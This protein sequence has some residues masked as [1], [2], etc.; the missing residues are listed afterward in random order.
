MPKNEEQPRSKKPIIIAALL[1]G[2]VLAG[3]GY[4]FWQK[5]INDAAREAALQ[6]LV[7]T[8]QPYTE[9]V[10]PPEPEPPPTPMPEPLA[11]PIPPAPKPA[12]HA[13]KTPPAP[14]PVAAVSPCEQ[15]RNKLETIF[16]HLDKQSY[17][18]GYALK[19]GSKKRI[20]TIAKKLY[21]NPPVV[22]RE[23]DDLFSIL[24]NSAH[25]YRILGK[26][27]L[28]LTKDILSHEADNLE[29]MMA[30]FYHWSEVDPTCKDQPYAL[31]M[32]LKSLYEYAGF[33]INTLGGQSYLFRRESKVRMLIKYYSVMIIDRANDEGI[34]RHGLDIR[35]PLRSTIDEM[36]VS[37]NL[38]NQ[39]TY[40][41]NLLVMQAK[42]EEKYGN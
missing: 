20:A 9:K 10:A 3:A 5:S 42:Y 38:Q 14:A 4:F 33:F 29:P 28:L 39:V 6:S 21:A 19:N 23:T 16:A 30:D 2:L 18:A 40:L 7:A 37:S 32:P 12:E 25:F 22:N 13:P 1:V 24:T 8:Q 36:R 15:A 27:N 31:H 17:I 26:D 34:N 41:E 11:L 35:T